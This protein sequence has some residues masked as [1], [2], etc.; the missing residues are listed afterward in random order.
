MTNIC[1][2]T[3]SPI[4]DG[5]CTL[6]SK[7]IPWS[8]L[9]EEVETET[10]TS[11]KTPRDLQRTDGSIGSLNTPSVDKRLKEA[12]EKV[13]RI[14]SVFGTMGTVLNICNYGLAIILLCA[15]FALS[16]YAENGGLALLVG[17]LI[18]VLVWGLGWMQVALLR[19]LSAFFLMRG[20]A[21]L[22]SFANN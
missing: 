9:K 6:C 4:N 2:H 22:K 16:S 18:T 15:T 5:F 3:N 7:P 13:V 17:F 10:S 20:L 19:G 11:K 1:Q 8:R 14:S 21:H 12:S